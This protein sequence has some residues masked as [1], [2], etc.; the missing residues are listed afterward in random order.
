MHEEK[1]KAKKETSKPAKPAAP[2]DLE[3]N[4]SFIEKTLLKTI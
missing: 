2:Q 1:E 3:E 4:K